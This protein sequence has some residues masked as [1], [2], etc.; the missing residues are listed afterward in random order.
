LEILVEGHGQQNS[1]CDAV[2]YSE[3]L[4]YEL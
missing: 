1:A 3:N 2:N 4:E